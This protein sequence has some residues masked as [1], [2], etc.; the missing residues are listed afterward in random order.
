MN[1]GIQDGYNLAWKLAMV[2]KH[3]ANSKLLETY[4]EERLP[5]AKRLTE[6]TD[7]MFNLAAGD[8]WFVGLIRN[9]VFPSMAKYIMSI[10]AV[11]KRFF[12]LISQIGINYRDYSLSAHEGD[13][14]FD[15]KA[16][17]RMPYFLVDGE[18][19]FDRLRAPKFHLVSFSDGQAES[20]E[21]TEELANLEWLDH[22]VVPLYP[23]VAELFGYSKSF[24]VLL[25]PDN[26]IA[27]ISGGNTSE[28]VS[29]YLQSWVQLKQL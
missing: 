27:Q 12:I 21:L 18:S 23:H 8:D 4:N 9:T 14:N 17:D 11:R 6:T 15:F 1:T 13:K 24:Y 10:E 20:F 16:G 26:Y 29:T 5:N 3:G 19:F 25:R 7:R 2:L 22:Q 28:A